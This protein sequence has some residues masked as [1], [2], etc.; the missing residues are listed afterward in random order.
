M[1]DLEEMGMSLL[2]LPDSSTKQKLSAQ[3][4]EPGCVS[5]ERGAQLGEKVS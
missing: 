3:P 5:A 1:E 4:D 2:M